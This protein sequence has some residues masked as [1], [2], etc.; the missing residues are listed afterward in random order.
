M[1]NRLRLMPVVVALVAL[2][3]TTACGQAPAP[4]P[5]P[6]APTSPLQGVWSLTAVDPGD[7]SAVIDP[8]QAGLYIFGE[9]YYSAVYAPG[10]EARVPAGIAFQPTPEEMVAQHESIIVNTGT[11]EIS[12]AT[13]TFRPII[14]KSPGFVGG[15]ATSEFQIDGDTLK[16]TGRT[17]VATD[18]TSAPD[19]S[20]VLV[21]RRV[22]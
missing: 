18:G 7:G 3:M 15:Q 22:E 12:G 5:E 20:G 4:P 2:T 13:V 11:Y 9:G 19:V 10:A 6:A 8:S 17:V 1:P 16:L 14:A 21:L